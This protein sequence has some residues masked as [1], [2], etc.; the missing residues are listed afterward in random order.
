MAFTANPGSRWFSDT[1]P[2]NRLSCGTQRKTEFLFV[3]VKGWNVASGRGERKLWCLLSTQNVPKWHH[4]PPSPPHNHPLLSHIAT[5]IYTFNTLT[6]HHVLFYIN[7]NPDS[8]LMMLLKRLI[9]Q[10]ISS[11]LAQLYSTDT[12]TPLTD[13]LTHMITECIS[14][15]TLLTHWSQ[16]ESHG[17]ESFTTCWSAVYPPRDVPQDQ[18]QQQT[19]QITTI[20][21]HEEQKSIS[22]FSWELHSAQAPHQDHPHSTH[23][24]QTLIRFTLHYLFRLDSAH[25]YSLVYRCISRCSE[26]LHAPVHTGYYY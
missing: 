22:I 7:V 16:S 10:I 18:A 19:L 25:L 20:Y 17:C 21:N 1:T 13:N 6:D 24:D 4:H 23:W 26:R 5:D 15:L 14:V 2:R 12:L 11:E 8:K 9:T 3:R